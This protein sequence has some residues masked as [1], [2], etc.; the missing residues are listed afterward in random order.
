MTLTM[1]DQLYAGLTRPKGARS[2]TALKKILDDPVKFH[3]MRQYQLSFLLWLKKRIDPKWASEVEFMIYCSEK[4]PLSLVDTRSTEELTS[5]IV[6]IIYGSPE[7]ALKSMV[8]GMKKPCK[9]LTSLVERAGMIGWDEASK[10]EALKLVKSVVVL[11][12]KG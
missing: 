11:I 5:E 10:N 4:E 6:R 7:A 8:N 3:E 1:L 2:K 9:V 12:E